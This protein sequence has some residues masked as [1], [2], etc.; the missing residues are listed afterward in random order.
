MPCI[1][2]V[3]SHIIDYT[4]HAT[5]EDGRTISITYDPRFF[6]GWYSQPFFKDYFKLG[7]LVD[8]TVIMWPHG[9]ET[10]LYE[11]HA[12]SIK[13]ESTQ[14]YCSNQSPSAGIL[15]KETIIAKLSE[16]LYDDY[17]AACTMPIGYVHDTITTLIE[18][19]KNN[20]IEINIG[21]PPIPLKEYSLNNRSVYLAFH[22]NTDIVIH[23]Y[24]PE[25][26]LAPVIKNVSLFNIPEYF[27]LGRIIDDLYLMW[28]FGEYIRLPEL[29]AYYTQNYPHTLLYQ[30]PDIWAGS[31]LE[32][33]NRQLDEKYIESCGNDIS[34]VIETINQIK[35]DI[36]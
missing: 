34:T 36:I 4:I 26:A 21:L 9:Y 19:I 10:Q 15:D 1:R 14:L 12:Y 13:I 31:Q 3:S 5:F 35:N 27:Q 33:L 18:N 23:Y 16:P 30:C 29:Y 20:M 6:M 11:W 8:D 17:I 2:A 7:I 32:L 25:F 22:D 28:P 24:N